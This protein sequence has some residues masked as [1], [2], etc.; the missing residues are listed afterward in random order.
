MYFRVS[1]NPDTISVR[2]NE[3][4]TRSREAMM[5]SLLVLRNPAAELQHGGGED[6]VAQRHGQEDLPAQP[7]QLVVA[8]ARQGSLGP[9]EDEEK[10][11]D[12]ESE[13]QHAP[14]ADRRQ[15]REWRHPAA[16]EQNGAQRGQQDHVGVFA[17]EKEREGHRRV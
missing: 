9:R 13:P 11:G 14:R 3:R 5:R 8:I 10:E 16:E 12:L 4:A 2:R 6:D 7:H 17:E 1:R 15:E